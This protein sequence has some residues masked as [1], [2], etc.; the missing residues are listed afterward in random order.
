MNEYG[1]GG[2]ITPDTFVAFQA[3]LN[4]PSL[5]DPYST[6]W[7]NIRDNFYG[8][9]G[10]PT[11]AFDGVDRRVGAQSNNATT[12]NW[13]LGAYNA[14]RGVPTDVIINVG[15]VDLGSRTYRI[16]A[17]ICIEAGAPSRTMRI[18]I[19]RTLDYFP[20]TGA[21]DRN[22]VMAGMTPGEDVY[23]RAGECHQVEHE[24][25]F[26]ATSWANQSNIRVFVWAQ[27]PNNSW[28]AEIY[29][30]AIM[31]WPFPPPTGDYDPPQPNP[32]TWDS[33]VQPVSTSEVTMTAT[34]GTDANEPVE[35][36]FFY[37][38]GTGA[39]GENSGWLESNTYNDSGL[40]PNTAYEYAVRS[41]D[42]APTP[43]YGD[44]SGSSLAATL[45][46]TPTGLLAG[47]ITSNSIEVTATGTLTNLDQAQSGLYFEWEE[48]VS[49]TPVGNSGWVQ[50]ITVTAGSLAPDTQYTIRVN[51]RNQ[52]AVETAG[53]ED[54]F[55]TLP[56]AAVCTMM[57]DVN[58]DGA[59][60]G[61]DGAAFLRVKLGVEL[62][63]D[64][65]ACAN[66]GGTLEED[67]AEFVGY[68]LNA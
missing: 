5:P 40:D 20:I 8:V 27:V 51:A 44:Y 47:A 56:D 9:T 61:A 10:L 24:F 4:P 34:P 57:G 3:H 7:G 33:V 12:Y 60:N 19:V 54:N 1:P 53:V 11:T 23:F 59:V 58:D 49:G 22:C 13:Y 55:T 21:E 30:S 35:Y 37:Y 43:N 32:M 38:P 6:P 67:T 25:T 39:G 46:E 14:R 45:I 26:D 65:P 17:D 52:D 68:L 28:A 36:F 66:Y 63:T 64:N 29:Q 15:A 2:T 16:V 31:S 18:N 41:R 42:S 48:T 62:P 50:T